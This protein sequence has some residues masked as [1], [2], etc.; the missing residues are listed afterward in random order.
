M[1]IPKPDKITG[2]KSSIKEVHY[3]RPIIIP[4]YPVISTDK[5]RVKLIKTIERLVRVC[6][7]YRDLISYL[8]NY[9]DMNQCEFFSNFKAGKRKGMIEI[10]HSPFDL[11]T[12]VDVV[13][14]R[15]EKKEGYISEL[16]VAD[17]VL[18]MHYEG[19]I[20]L[21]PLSITCHELVHD[22]KLIVPLNCVYGRF[23]EFTNEYYDELGEDRLEMLA[24]NI[25][26]TKSLKR[27][28]FNILNVQYVYTSIDGFNLPQLM[29]VDG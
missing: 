29:E 28:D 7:D 18:R 6:I 13:M 5:Q 15:M 23:S 1:R 4:R 11:F 10:H 9:I 22:G 2:N 16:V 27:S 26:L 12:I 8:R 24:E 17:R 14:T 20:G 21:I 3:E 19:L 25:K